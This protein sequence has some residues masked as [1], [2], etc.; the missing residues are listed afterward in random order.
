MLPADFYLN[1]LKP[2]Y[3]L[4]VDRRFGHLAGPLRLCAIWFFAKTQTV[5][6]TTV[7]AIN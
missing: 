4:G 1:G 7:N 6:E 2:V 3:Q 5:A